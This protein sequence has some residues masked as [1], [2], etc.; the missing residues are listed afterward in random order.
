MNTK[1]LILKKGGKSGVE[2]KDLNKTLRRIGFINNSY[3][4]LRFGRKAT[5]GEIKV[6]LFFCVN[7]LN[8]SKFSLKR[9]I[10]YFGET[11]I[12]S[13]LT[14]SNVLEQ[15]KKEYPV[16]QGRQLLL[17]EKDSNVLTKVFRNYSLRGQYV[18]DRK[19]LVI[20]ESTLPI[21]QKDEV[22]IYYTV[23]K[24]EHDAEE[25][26]KIEL[27][28]VH[29]MKVNKQ[30]NLREMGDLILNDLRQNLET[31]HANKEETKKIMEA[32]LQENGVENIR[33][34]KIRDVANFVPM[35]VLGHKFFKMHRNDQVVS[36]SPFYLE[37]DG[38]LFVLKKKGLNFSNKLKQSMK[39]VLPRNKGF[40][41]KGGEQNLQI[42]IKK[43]S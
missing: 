19:N 42:F 28:P 36:S 35:D 13:R 21:P 4:F 31:N 18:Y 6:N 24:H 32:F 34:T 17:R 7:S 40:F 38:C 16:L 39:R 3:L 41:E 9:E 27:T 1:N 33:C 10:G 30:N 2:L 11:Y 5:P 23:L 14:A 37:N 29:Q 43:K 15:L 20:E 25:I 22:V 26:D 8:E 12:L